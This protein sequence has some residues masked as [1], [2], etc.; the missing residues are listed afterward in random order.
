[1][2]DEFVKGVLIEMLKDGSFEL[3]EKVQLIQIARAMGDIS[4]D[5]AVEL[6]LE[7]LA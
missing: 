5:D 7:Y 1:M 3:K 6:A 2:M 4:S